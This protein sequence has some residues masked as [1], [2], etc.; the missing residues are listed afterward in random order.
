MGELADYYIDQEI[1]RNL[2]I[3]I[4]DIELT[5]QNLEWSTKDGRKIP[6]KDMEDNHLLN[7]AS[8]MKRNGHGKH[9]IYLRL[10]EEIKKRKLQEVLKHG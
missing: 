10:M 3:K 1:G 6:I 2:D 7:S 8:M 9:I 4:H 5:F